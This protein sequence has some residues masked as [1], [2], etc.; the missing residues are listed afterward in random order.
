MPLVIQAFEQAAL[1][2]FEIYSFLDELVQTDESVPWLIAEI[3]RIDLDTD[4]RSSNFFTG[5]VAALRHADAAVLKPIHAAIER[6]RRLDDNSK[7]I[8]AQRIFICSLSLDDLWQDLMD[9]QHG[10]PSVR[11]VTRSLFAAVVDCIQLDASVG[12]TG[13]ADATP[14]RRRFSR[15]KLRSSRECPMQPATR[16]I[17]C[18]RDQLI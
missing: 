13:A 10:E 4:A 6:M 8:I 18:G 7:K 11:A 1:K 3:E 17:A 9:W 16:R 14:N 2:A 12:S 15:S 5:C